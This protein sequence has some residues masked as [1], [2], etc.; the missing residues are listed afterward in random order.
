MQQ[1]KIYGCTTD[2]QSD[3]FSDAEA[4]CLHFQILYH[5]SDKKGTE[6]RLPFFFCPFLL[7]IMI[8]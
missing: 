3:D 8:D 2:K 5:N 6:L 1:L 7:I 4:E